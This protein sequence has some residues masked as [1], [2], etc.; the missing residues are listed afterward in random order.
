MDSSTPIEL[1]VECPSGWV[2]ADGDNAKQLMAYTAASL[3]RPTNE[4]V[5]V[6]TIAQLARRIARALE[7]S[8]DALQEGIAETSRTATFT[9]DAMRPLRR[10][11]PVTKQLFDFGSRTDSAATRQALA[12]MAPTDARVETAES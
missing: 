1:T 3:S 6:P 11:L 4:P 10:K 12:K 5:P 7:N 8:E 2:A 9:D